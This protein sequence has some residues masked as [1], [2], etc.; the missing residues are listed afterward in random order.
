[1]LLCLL[2]LLGSSITR[3]PTAFSNTDVHV[4]SLQTVLLPTHRALGAYCITESQFSKIIPPS[5]PRRF[6]YDDVTHR[7]QLYNHDFVFYDI[8]QCY[9]VDF[10]PFL[11]KFGVGRAYL[12][13]LTGVCDSIR[14]V[15]R[16]GASVRFMLRVDF[17][18]W[19]ASFG[20]PMCFFKA[21]RRA[22]G[23]EV[24]RTLAGRAG[25]FYFQVQG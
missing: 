13:K 21:P 10:L 3:L 9:G 5:R 17:E 25:Q 7:H 18:T 15:L 4:Q 8:N 1:M 12:G 14:Y 6:D 24:R 2:R 16:V 23:N 20:I 11:P 19:R 22:R